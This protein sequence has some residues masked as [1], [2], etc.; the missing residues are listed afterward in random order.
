[1]IVRPEI[2]SFADLKGKLIGLSTAGDTITLSAL[3]L[4]ASKG[5]RAEDFHSKTVVGTPA[6][7]GCLKS[8]EC[9]AVP[10][11]QPEDLSA[12]NL[13]FPRLAFTNEAGADLIFNVDMTRR[14]WGEKNKQA[15]VRLVR[16]FASA[17]KFIND[18]KNHDEVRNIV[19]ESLKISDDTAR[20][21]FR[22]YTEPDKNVL[23]RRGELDLAAFDRVLV[24]MGQAGVIP[25][26][27]AP[28]TRFLDLQYLKAAGI[29]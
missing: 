13:G 17:Y 24:L 4:L 15:L 8:A 6:R 27:V 12:I 11:G 23:P 28:T 9:A 10:I 5:L 3:R 22:P 29:Q 7:F 19:K 21:I 2:K 1:L 16:G 14:A 18:A 25:T 20:Q 26:P